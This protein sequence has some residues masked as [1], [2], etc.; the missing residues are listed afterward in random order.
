MTTP[1]TSAA[2]PL[3]WAAI[4]AALILTGCRSPSPRSEL[5]IERLYI[6]GPLTIGGADLST[7]I[8]GGGEV[9]TDATIPVSALP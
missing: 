4:A 7:L 9:V 8:D 1:N 3:A 5:H 6:V 2:N